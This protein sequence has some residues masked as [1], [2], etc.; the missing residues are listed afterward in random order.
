M[1]DWTKVEASTDEELGQG[2]FKK[3]PAGKY[4]VYIVK[5]AYNESKN[6]YEL[7]LDVADGEYKDIG[8]ENERKNGN[9][10]GYKKLFCSLKVT[11]KYNGQKHFKRLLDALEASN[12]RKFKVANFKGDPKSLEG[13]EFGVV[14]DEDVYKGKKIVKP[15]FFLTYDVDTIYTDKARAPHY[16]TDD[17]KAELEDNKPAASKPV[18]YAETEK[19]VLNPEETPF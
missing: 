4:I 10:Y 16:L 17:E 12:G 18:T 14:M 2:G 3:L 7:L 15:N 13:L 9:E 11:E 8:L 1:I 19:Y 6:G 5:A